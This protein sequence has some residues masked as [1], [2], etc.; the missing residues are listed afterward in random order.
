MNNLIYFITPT[1]GLIKNYVKYKKLNPLIFIRTPIFYIFISMILSKLK[2][3]NIFLT[4]IVERWLLFFIKIIRSH[5]NNNYLTKK[6]KYI[7]KYG[8]NYPVKV[9]ME[10]VEEQIPELSS[11]SEN[12]SNHSIYEDTD[13]PDESDNESSGSSDIKAEIIHNN[14]DTNNDDTIDE[15]L[16]AGNSIRRG[17]PRRRINGK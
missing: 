4:L 6:N 1:F 3:N 12:E 5:Y 16:N 7:L 11:E 2:V 8:F 17:P 10:P 9:K 13:K 15:I 14:D